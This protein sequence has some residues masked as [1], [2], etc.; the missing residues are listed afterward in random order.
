MNSHMTASVN[1]S[2]PTGEPGSPGPRDRYEQITWKLLQSLWTQRR[3]VLACIA[4]SLATSFAGLAY[5]GPRYTSEALIHITFTREEPN[6]AVRAAPVAAMDAGIMV[7]SAARLM[8]SRALAS[9][10]VSRLALDRETPPHSRFAGILARAQAFAGISEPPLPAHET[11]V[12]RLLGQVKVTNDLRSY[13]ITISVTAADPARAARLANAVAT[14]YLRG[15]A[16]RQAEE[17]YAAAEREANDLSAV[18]GPR[19]PQYRDARAKQSRLEQQLAALRDAPIETVGTEAIVVGQTLVPAETIL[20][21]SVPNAAI[22]F[23][24]A[25]ALGLLAGIGLAVLCDRCPGLR[26]TRLLARS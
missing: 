6:T 5:V 15:Q 1:F 10:V 11:A 21:P 20:V 2:V 19:H 12:T 13:L 16:L 25:A 23:S 18:F 14:E 9:A 24:V 7:E 3:L 22:V 17:S 8:H 26:I 4:T